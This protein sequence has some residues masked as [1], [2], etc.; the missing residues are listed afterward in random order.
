M[1]LHPLVP[2]SAA[3]VQRAARR[4]RRSLSRRRPRRACPGRGG[5]PGG[6]TPGLLAQYP[7]D[8]ASTYHRSQW[9]NAFGAAGIHLAASANAPWPQYWFYNW[10]W[11][12]S[13]N[14][15]GPAHSEATVLFSG[16]HGAGANLNPQTFRDGMFAYPVSPTKGGITKPLVAFGRKLWTWDDY[17]LFDDSTEIWW[18]NTAQGP[19]EVNK[20]GVGMYRYLAGGQRVL[21]RQVPPRPG[22]TIARTIPG[23]PPPLPASSRR[24][25]LHCANWR[26]SGSTT[27]RQSNKCCVNI[28]AGSRTAVRL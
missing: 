15:N 24:L 28:C 9:R 19:D 6:A 14:Q 13:D 27:A 10:Y 4:S 7:R 11:G 25:P 23:R 3:L 2:E 8:G 12:N 5:V 21:P 26:R 18:D 1:G 22:P 17:N 20:P 16:I